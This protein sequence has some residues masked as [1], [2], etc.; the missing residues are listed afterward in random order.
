[1]DIG[2]LTVTFGMDMNILNGNQ[3]VNFLTDMSPKSKEG[4]RNFSPHLRNSEILRQPKQ[5]RKC[6]CGPSKFDFRNST[7]LCSFRLVQLLYC[8]FSSAQL[9]NNF[10]IVCFY[11]NQKLALKRTVAGDFWSQISVNEWTLYGFLIHTL[12]LGYHTPPNKFLRGIMPL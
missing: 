10:R 5:L 8:P 2:A 6:D 9:K 12:N 1:M 7:T 4:I 11:G 3:L